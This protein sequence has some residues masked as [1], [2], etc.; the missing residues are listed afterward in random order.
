MDGPSHGNV[1][2]HAKKKLGNKR[3]FKASWPIKDADGNSPDQDRSVRP[4]G[5]EGSDRCRAL[6]LKSA[7]ITTRIKAVADHEKERKRKTR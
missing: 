4:S 1:T 5:A 7:R 3:A 2:E 6:T